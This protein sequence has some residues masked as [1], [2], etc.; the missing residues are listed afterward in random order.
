MARATGKPLDAHRLFYNYLQKDLLES[1]VW[2]FQMLTARLV[3]ALGVWLH[4][5]IYQRLPIGIPYAVRDPLCRPNKAQ[6]REDAW[7]SPDATG[8]FRDDNSMVKN[9]PRSLRIESG[10]P[11]FKG[12]QIG[13]GFVAAHLWRRLGKSDVTFASRNPLTYSFVPNIVWLPSEV[14]ALTD[15]EAS[16]VQSFTQAVSMKI[17]RDLPVSKSAKPIV[18]QAWKLLPVRDD[19]PP[20]GLPSI[21]SLN[22]FVPTEKWLNGKISKIRRVAD[23]LDAVVKGAPATGFRISKRYDEGLPNVAPDA[24]AALRDHL[25]RLTG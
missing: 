20:Q 4:P 15:R 24:A 18:E 19:I 7:G 8:Y 10:N 13:D 17:F 16:F 12:R 2:L 23:A 25:L 6:G 3:V 14:A 11:L 22:Y 5:D 9:F 21:D 1:D